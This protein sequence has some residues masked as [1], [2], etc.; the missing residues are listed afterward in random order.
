MQL[1]FSTNLH[2]VWALLPEILLCG[3]GMVVLLAGVWGRSDERAGEAAGAED[4]LRSNDLGWLSLVGV[5]LAALA[6]GWLYGVREVGTGSM[7][8]VDGFRLFANWIFL[9]AAGMAI[10]VS[11]AYVYRQRLQ[12]GEYYGLILLAT[13][14]MMFMVGG[15]DLIVIFL[16]LEVMSIAVYA[17]TAFNRRD[18]R[19][20]EAGLKYF[21]L[22]AFSTGFF[23]YGIALTYGATGST[24][25]LA[26]RVAVDTGAAQGALLLFG[27]A[28]LAVGFAFKVSAVPFHMWTPDVYEGAPSPITAFMSGA[29]KAAAFAAFLR[30]FVVG[31]LGA[32]EVWSGILWWLAALTMVVANLVALVQTNVKRMLAYSSVAHGGYLLVAITAANQTASAGLL[33]YLL[34]YTIMNIGAFAVIIAVA[35]Q[36]EERLQ[37]DDYAGL[38][39]REPLL[40]L[41]LTVFLL[42]LA[43]F[44]GT[45]GFMAKIFL[46]QGAADASLWTLAVVLVLTTLVSYYYYLRLAWYAW[47]RDP[48]NGEDEPAVW[49]PL[50]MRVALAAGV[51]AI[52]YTGIFPSST[53]ELARAS[54]Q[55]L[56]AAGGALVGPGF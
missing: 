53:I 14:G 10:L 36:G 11:F 42:S 2:Y 55:G 46:L 1:D 28:L 40:A 27:I 12:S 7:V 44:P 24:N 26:I 43:G 17:L 37:I 56:R 30:V 23:L 4:G 16:G 31:F 38:G 41:A 32:Y 29:V 34:V 51:A 54:V 8:A 47:M 35:R 5:L 9:V 49:V 15:R 18:R 3:W 50:P 39:H 52:L 33:F 6:N 45:G 13:A 19:S 20:A 21:L 25:L 22:G 48:L